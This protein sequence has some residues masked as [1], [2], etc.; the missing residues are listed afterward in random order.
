ME[1]NATYVRDTGELASDVLTETTF[2]LD[3]PQKNFTNTKF[4]YT[5]DL[6]NG[7]VIRGTE[8]VVRYYYPASGNYTLSLK[9]GL[10][11]TEPAPL[12]SDVYSRNIKVLGGCTLTML[13]ENTLRL[14]HTFTSAGVHCLDLI[15]Q[16]DISKLQTSFSL[17]VKRNSE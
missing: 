11:L 9:V 16:N 12:L 17:S 3:D 10:N 1:G 8:P 2:E 15:V 14:N 7:E 13:Y 4:T 5:W 6:G